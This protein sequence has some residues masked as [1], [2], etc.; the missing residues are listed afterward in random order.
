MYPLITWNRALT[1]VPRSK[2]NCQKEMKNLKCNEEGFQNVTNLLHKWR[3][4]HPRFHPWTGEH[5]PE[6]YDLPLS[7]PSHL[8]AYS[9]LFLRLFDIWLERSV[10]LETH[11]TREV[12]VVNTNPVLM[13]CLLLPLKY[14]LKVSNI[15]DPLQLLILFTLSRHPNNAPHQKLWFHYLPKN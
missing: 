7:H 4:P 15:W 14:C 6:I 13:H 11:W 8:V 1:S 9:L 10:L 3:S 2:L 12:A 5:T